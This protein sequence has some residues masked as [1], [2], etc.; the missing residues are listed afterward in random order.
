MFFAAL[1]PGM[2]KPPSAAA[3]KREAAAEKDR[4]LANLRELLT[5][6]EEKSP[7]DRR[8]ARA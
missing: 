7:R 2:V 4:E 6:A 8:R 3:L 1:I 5:H